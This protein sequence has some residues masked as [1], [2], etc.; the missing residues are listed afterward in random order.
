M[1]TTILPR[2]FMLMGHFDTIIYYTGYNCPFEKK[3]KGRKEIIF[4]RA[5]L[6]LYTLV[7]LANFVQNSR[8]SNLS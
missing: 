1:T 3:K 8:K 6:I 5:K 2:K 4:T 7:L